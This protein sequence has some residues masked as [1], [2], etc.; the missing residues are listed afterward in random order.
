MKYHV[1]ITVPMYKET[2]T[3]LEQISFR[4]LRNIL[5]HYRTVVI[6]PASLNI[7]RLLAENPNI[8]AES[9]DDSYFK[10]VS[11]YN[12]LMMSEELYRRFEDSEYILVYQ[13]DA[14]V[15]R[16]ELKAWCDRGY[17]YIGA[18]WLPRP[19]HKFPLMRL[20]SWIKK[21]YCE[22]I[23]KPDNNMIRFK[24]GNGGFSLRKTASH[25]KAVTELRKMIEFYSANSD[26]DTVYNEDVFFSIEV[27]RH[28]MGFTYPEWEEALGFS[29][30]IHPE[31]CYRQNGYKLPFGCHGWSKW[32]TRKF[33][34]PF[35][36]QN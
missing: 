12:R 20:S 18:P 23:G 36:P 30:D 14:Y 2:M 11:G 25:L 22:K 27:N 17:D 9:F 28:G 35:I 1:T 13:L 8:T 3:P 21:V 31:T 19:I 4:Q 24:V 7:N 26:S 34:S 32:K 15:F 5:G 33:W 6:K 16:D 29:F 10:G